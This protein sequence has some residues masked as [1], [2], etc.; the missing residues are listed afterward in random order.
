MLMALCEAADAAGYVLV[1]HLT[2]LHSVCKL[3]LMLMVLCEVAAA[4][5]Y[6]LVSHLPPTPG[7]HPGLGL[8][9]VDAPLSGAP[10]PQMAL[11]P[12]VVVQH[13]AVLPGQ[14]EVEVSGGLHGL[15]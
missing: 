2:C 10:A 5:G 15:D 11:L 13:T 12:R 8:R 1:S 3:C 14:A 7:Q 6:V 4:A 9:L